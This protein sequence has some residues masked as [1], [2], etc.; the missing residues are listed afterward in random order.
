MKQANERRSGQDRRQDDKGFPGKVERRR[1]IEQRK[2]EIVELSISEAE[3][4]VLVAAARA[5]AP[6]APLSY[7]EAQAD[8]V[9]ERAGN[10]SC[11]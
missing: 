10:R 7:R 4:Q 9:F 3:W 5:C 8:L 1:R 6:P 2:I 11:G